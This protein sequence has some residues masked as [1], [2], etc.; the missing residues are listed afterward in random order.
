MIPLRGRWLSAL[1]PLV[2]VAVALTLAGACKHAPNRTPAQEAGDAFVDHYLHADQAG[3][4]PYAELG[5]KKQLESEIASVKE[6]RDDAAPDIHA[7]W[8]RTAEEAR[9]QRTVLLYQVEPGEQSSP[10]TMRLEVT[11]LGKGPRVVLYELR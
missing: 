8:K 5:A 2:G 9:G 11:D 3:A 10:R 7:T 6:A 4:L 1:T